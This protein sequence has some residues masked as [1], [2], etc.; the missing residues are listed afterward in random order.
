[1]ERTIDNIDDWFDDNIGKSLRQ[2]GYCFPK[3]MADFKKIE[4]QVKKNKIAV[5]D[6]L[7]NPYAFLGKRNFNGLTAV[8]HEEEQ[9]SY[10]QN[11]SQAAREGKGI[12]DEVRKRMNED[13]LN[14]GQKKNEN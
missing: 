13:K 2:L 14:A 8:G 12:S 4:S 5:P 3:T 10:T 11:L 1:M 9:T 6:K 7:K